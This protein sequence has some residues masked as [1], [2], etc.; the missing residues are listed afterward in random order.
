MAIVPAVVCQACRRE[1]SSDAPSIQFTRIPQADAAG[2]ARNDI[3]EGRVTGGLPGQKIVLYAKTG[4]WWVQPLVDQP[5]TSIRPNSKWTN[6]THL[7]TDYAALLVK[8]GYRVE[9]VLDS[10]PQTGGSVLAIAVAPGA[11]RPPSPVVDFSGYQWRLRDAPSSRGGT[12][13]Y[14]S[15]N[16]SV[17]EQGAMHVRISKTEKDWSCAEAS[18]TR[19]LGY[20]TYEFVVRGLEKLEPAAVFSMFTYDYASGSLRNR[21]MNIEIGRWGDPVNKNAQYA[22]QPF[23]VATNV[24]RFNIPSGKLTFSMRWEPG[25]ITFRTLRGSTTVAEHAFT[26]GV[27]PPGIESMRV[28]FYV[29]RAAEV[30]LLHP[31]EVVIE[32]FTYYP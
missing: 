15:S 24:Y 5:L 29:Y 17:D 26:V 22:L 1:R 23:D 30:K 6:A 10:L 2:S 9:N 32:R 19:N 18:L 25:R 4:Q 12:N 13:V 8:E 21:E 20:G 11:K 31:M 16:I 14:S 7:G 27:P 28:A 3:I